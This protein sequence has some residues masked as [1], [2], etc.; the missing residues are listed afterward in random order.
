MRVLYFINGFDPGGAEH[1]LLTLV[2]NGFFEDQ[3]LRVLGMCRG[4]G[5]L[6]GELAQ[7]LGADKVFIARDEERL[8]LAGS[9]AGALALVRHLR[10]FRPDAVVLSL[11]QANVIGR[12]VL[13]A[14]PSVRCISFEHISRYRAKRAEGI[15]GTVLKALSRRVDEVW[16]DC[17]ETLEA[18]RT[19]FSGRAKREAVVPLFCANEGLAVKTDY[20]LGPALRLSAAGR[21]VDRK[22]FD[23]LIAAVAELNNSGMDTSLTIFGDGPEEAG[24]RAKVDVLQMGGKVTLAGYRPRW[25]EEARQS[26]IFVN[27]SDTEGFCIVVAEAMAV[28][29][30]VIATNV[31]GIRE[32]GADGTNM[33]KL[34]DDSVASIAAAL[35]GLAADE[36]RRRLLGSRARS[37]IEENYTPRAIAERGKEIFSGKAGRL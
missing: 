5:K 9:L 31:G 20:A 17:S 27:A 24:L 22:N 18:T 14:F 28:G 23:R 16:S 21:L 11:K 35:R 34:E 6:A 7:A 10:E 8:S 1:G 29:L 4:R 32:Y 25:F 15:Y 36:T 19:Y 37:D 3:E 2:R 12:F 13:L 30:P 26:D 33:L